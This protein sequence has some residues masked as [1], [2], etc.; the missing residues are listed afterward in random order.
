MHSSRGRLR[1][2]VEMCLGLYVMSDS[3][4]DVRIGM[5]GVVCC[6]CFVLCVFPML[7]EWCVVNA[8]MMSG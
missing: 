4:D 7:L 1:N 3:L 5:L 6:V 8:C 2:Q